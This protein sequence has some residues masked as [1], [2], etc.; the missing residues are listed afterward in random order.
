M[1]SVS[2]QKK[3]PH[4]QGFYKSQGSP[5]SQG[6]AHLLLSPLPGE[7]EH[8]DPHFPDEGTEART[9]E[10]IQPMCGRAGTATFPRAPPGLSPIQADPG[11]TEHPGK[12]TL[13]SHR[14]RNDGKQLSLARSP[15]GQTSPSG[16]PRAYT[17]QPG[18]DL[19][20]QQSPDKHSSGPHRVPD[21]SPVV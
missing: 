2:L 16:G 12:A 8:R 21:S 6:L 15:K 7:R 13:G 1:N 10:V 4:T 14:K 5:V 17:P 18:R 20:C 19:R 9:S 3:S 11:T